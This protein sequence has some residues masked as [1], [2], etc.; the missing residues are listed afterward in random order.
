MVKRSAKITDSNGD[1]K[2][3]QDLNGGLEKLEKALKGKKHKSL[4]IHF[5][6]G[7]SEWRIDTFC[8]S[9]FLPEKLKRKMPIIQLKFLAVVLTV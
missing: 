6:T 3:P 7:V 2:K 1:L 9:H 8:A 5:V 4:D